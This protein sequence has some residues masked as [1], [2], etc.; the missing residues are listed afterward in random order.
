MKSEICFTFYI[1]HREGLDCDGG[2]DI[3][4][5]ASKAIESLCLLVSGGSSY[6]KQVIVVT[7]LT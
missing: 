4:G 7:I 2:L 3:L 5:E 6:S 1:W